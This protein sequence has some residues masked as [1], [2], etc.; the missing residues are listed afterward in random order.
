[1]DERFW[2]LLIYKMYVTDKER[3]EIAGCLVPFF[4]VALVVSGI[5][6]L[7]HHFQN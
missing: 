1:M 7:V 6:W 5:Y 2:N 4:A 3:D